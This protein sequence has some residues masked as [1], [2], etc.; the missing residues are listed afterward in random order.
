MVKTINTSGILGYVK[1]CRKRQADQFYIIISKDQF[2]CLAKDGFAELRRILCLADYLPK[3]SYSFRDGRLNIS[4]LIISTDPRYDVNN[5]DEL[6][7]ALCMATTGNH[8]QFRVMMPPDLLK[9]LEANNDSEL[10]K[11]EQGLSVQE[12]KRR[13][14]P[15]VGLLL[16]EA[17]AVS[18]GNRYYSER[19][20]ETSVNRKANDSDVK[21]K[22]PEIQVLGK[23]EDVI[24]YIES[25]AAKLKDE[26]MLHCSSDIYYSLK[27]GG[28]INTF[29]EKIPRIQALAEQ[30]G[31]M[32]YANTQWDANYTI[33]LNY[34]QYYPGYKVACAVKSGNIGLLSSKEQQLLAK[35][36]KL[37]QSVSALSPTDKVA[38]LSHEIG[39]IT[40][41]V[42]DETTNE[43]DCAY[44]PLINGKA[45]CDGYS[46]A[47]YLCASLAGIDVRY[48]FGAARN[49]KG[50]HLWNLVKIQ[51]KWTSVDVTWDSDQNKTGFDLMYCMIGR[52]R[53]EK[54]YI[55][56]KDMSPGLADKTDFHRSSLIP[57]G[58][59][60]SKHDIVNM[61]CKTK[62]Q[63]KRVI[64][65]F[66]SN[67]EIINNVNVLSSCLRD[68]GIHKP[69]QYRE[70]K[71][72]NAITIELNY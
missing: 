42:I 58:F 5:R 3:F 48:Q 15:A 36:R 31:I 32:K 8:K 25:E 24:H 1:E 43:D 2:E 49:Y 27:F 33:R 4:G 17:F 71:A 66:L 63:R 29:G 57:E 44:G 14:Y 39:K 50:L 18:A 56:E 69:C 51:N 68:A 26:I 21:R 62:S 11:L 30:A 38:M 34:I 47:F 12:S 6:R 70:I 9:T 67:P 13:T 53:L 20:A 60:D 45:N 7:N 16:Y 55:W 40:E 35:A 22:T 10:L 65:L 52:D 28:T 54:L 59:C 61:I 37:A 41:Y 19:P 64:H 72:L 23:M 46:D